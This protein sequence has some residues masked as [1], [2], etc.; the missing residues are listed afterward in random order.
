MGQVGFKQK[1]GGLNK[2]LE[3]TLSPSGLRREVL[4]DR[5]DIIKI[6][7]MHRKRQVERMKCLEMKIN[8]N[9]VLNV[10]LINN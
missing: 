4:S 10:I 3:L 6:W 8:Q 2:S 1:T 5:I 9:T 7:V